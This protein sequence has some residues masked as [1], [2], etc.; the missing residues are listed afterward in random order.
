LFR[1]SDAGFT[2]SVKIRK[3]DDMATRLRRKATDQHQPPPLSM[4]TDLSV[5]IARRAY[6]LYL[7]RG[8]EHGRDVDDWL[9]AERELSST[10][11]LQALKE[12]E[13]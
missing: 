3:E 4:S 8:A 7:R 5:D 12:S 11:S 1:P 10:T 9:Q 6:E 13:S 2:N